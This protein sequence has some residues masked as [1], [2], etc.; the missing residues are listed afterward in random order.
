MWGE[1][2]PG[3]GNRREDELMT[4]DGFW[5]RLLEQGAS[6]FRQDRGSSSANEIIRFLISRKHRVV[7]DIQSE[8]VDRNK[9]L[10][11]TAAGQEISAELTKQQKRYEAEL[12]SIKS[13]MQEALKAKDNELSRELQTV[14]KEV[15]EKLEQERKAAQRL[16]ASRDDLY[17]QMQEQRDKDR[18]MWQ[19][20]LKSERKSRT[21]ERRELERQV[22]DMQT[23]LSNL[24]TS[25]TM[26]VGGATVTVHNGVNWRWFDKRCCRCGLIDDVQL[27]PGKWYTLR[28]C[29]CGHGCPKCC[30]IKLSISQYYKHYYG[31]K[32]KWNYFGQDEVDGY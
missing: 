32:G 26:R 8:M 9:R 19:K 20:L 5:K 25:N 29:S 4:Q 30:E 27:W 1:V 21:E 3:D 7:F 6:I 28:R 23:Q 15:E 2:D 18:E 11:E 16:Q 12:L 22:S 13:E 31:T 14:K 10:D 17:Q 24:Q